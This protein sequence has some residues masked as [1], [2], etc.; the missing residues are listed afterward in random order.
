MTADQSQIGRS[1]RSGRSVSV[2][3]DENVV[4]DQYKH[5]AVIDQSSVISMENANAEN[6]MYGSNA[7]SDPKIVLNKVN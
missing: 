5:K 2:R 6:D 4:T 1:G 3:D 7:F